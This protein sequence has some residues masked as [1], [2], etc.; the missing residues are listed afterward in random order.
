MAFKYSDYLLS[1][2]D[3]S[4][5]VLYVLKNLRPVDVVGEA[6]IFL[7]LIYT[8]QALGWEM[9]MG[10]LFAALF[11][12]VYWGSTPARESLRLLENLR[13][14][15]F[16]GGSIIF[17]ILIYTTQYLGWEIESIFFFI[18][19]F[20][21]FY[22]NLDARISISFALIYLAIGSFF[23]FLSDGYDF[24]QGSGWAEWATVWAYYFL[25]FG[26]AKQAWDLRKESVA[27]NGR[28]FIVDFRVAETILAKENRND[29]VV[30]KYQEKI[31]K[32]GEMPRE[33]SI[34]IENVFAPAY[35]LAREK[36]E[37]ERFLPQAIF[38]AASCAVMLPIL[39]QSGYLFLLDMVWGPNIRL[40]DYAVGGTASSYPLMMLLKSFSL[41]LPTAFLQ[42]ALLFFVLY[43]CGFWMFD[44]SRTLMPRRWAILS[45]VFYILNPYVFERLLAGQWLVLLGYAFFP[46]VI[47]RFIKFLESDKGKDFWISAALFSIYPILSPH[48]AYMA[49]WLLLLLAI[50]Y[51]AASIGFANLKKAEF[52]PARKKLSLF[53][54]SQ[55]L[56]W[57]MVNSFWLKHF[58]SADGAIAKITQNDFQAFRTTADPVWGATFN[59]LSLYGFWQDIFFLPKDVFPYWWALTFIV[60]AFAFVGFSHLAKKKNILALT[61]GIAFVPVVLIA[62][63]YGTTVTRM[64]T[65]FLFHYLPGFAGMRETA[66]A[67]GVIA[68][69]YA[70][71]F[72]LGIKL[73]ADRFGRDA[74]D[75]TKKTILFCSFALSVLFCCLW[76]NNIFFGFAG[77]MRA[78][79]YPDSWY[80]A[81]KMLDADAQTER[82]LFL[83]WHGYLK[84]AFANNVTANNPAKVFFSA[85]IISGKN[86]DSIY[87]TD[88]SQAQWDEKI[89]AMLRKDQKLED[90]ISFLKTQGISHIIF[91]KTDDWREYDFIKESS[92]VRKIYEAKG[93]VLYKIL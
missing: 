33:S 8:K 67:T 32:N 74:Q 46:L 76:V 23:L 84:I 37:K 71:F 92:G 20:I 93:I 60:I 4:R 9:G 30:A 66:K 28:N 3:I 31:F 49:F 61:L 48:W 62:T 57:I 53:V 85:E 50:V 91:A 35:A 41:F 29:T 36:K 88:R 15:D 70:L 6:V 56:L 75:R 18:F 2:G 22:W 63:G 44:L 72:P 68:F 55:G 14:F 47:Y 54:I 40:S 39:F 86:L 69:T 24:L 64:I 7:I 11:A 21:T 79:P 19:L 12:F 73:T 65:N 42:K 38:F 52:A 43:L 10:L 17:F 26:V 34:K 5:G 1:P 82:V 80:K 13:P 78:Y 58:W 83:P 25:V 77:Q 45:G 16:A 51:L 90:N 59:V 27:I 89:A 81:E 87:I